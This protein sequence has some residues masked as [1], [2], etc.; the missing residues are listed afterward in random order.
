MK[1]LIRN[2]AR[3]LS[4]WL[5]KVGLGPRTIIVH[6][7]GGICSQMHFYLVGRLLMER[8]NRVEFDTDWF[9]LCGRDSNGV[10][11]RNFELSTLFPALDLPVCNSR[12]KKAV[13]RRLFPL[14]NEYFSDL[15]DALAWTRARGPIYMDGYFRDPEELYLELFRKTFVCGQMSLDQENQ[16][17]LSLIKLAR[18][19]SGAC[20]IHVRRGD[21]AIFHEAYGAPATAGYFA[22]AISRILKESPDCRFFMFSDEPE[23]CRAELIPK[24]AI[25]GFDAGHVLVCDVNGPDRGCCDLEL[26]AHC[27]YQIVSQGSMGKYAALLRPDGITGGLVILPPNTESQQWLSRFP[28]AVIVD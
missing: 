15:I 9:R 20:A 22:S 5:N 19:D 12:L 23:W 11:P 26:M 24:I 2:M 6:V 1:Q 27:P 17:I 4:H 3:R 28:N 8:G 14:Y 7:D 18:E 16:R 21:L 25:D 13:Y 10:H